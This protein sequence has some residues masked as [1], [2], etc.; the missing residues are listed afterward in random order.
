MLERLFP[1]RIDNTYRGYRV[2]LWLFGL[3]LFMRTTISV[4]SIFSGHSVAS[5]AD[6]IPLATYSAPASWTSAQNT[7]S[8]MP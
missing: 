7:K 2:A 6:G 5:V 1:A 4:R 3:M 8:S